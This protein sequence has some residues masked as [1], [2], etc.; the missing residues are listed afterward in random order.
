MPGYTSY[1]V[2]T[3]RHRGSIS[4]GSYNYNSGHTSIDGS[5][6]GTSTTMIPVLNPGYDI[7]Y[8]GALLHV[9][10]YLVVYLDRNIFD[11][12]KD[13][14][15]AKSEI[16]LFPLDIENIDNIATDFTVVEVNSNSPF[17]E[18]GI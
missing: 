17:E 4:G 1:D 12:L 18:A 10:A 9:Y 8:S 13:K 14:G 11:T 6:S 2:Q 3:T 15:V 5:Y 16:P 7:P